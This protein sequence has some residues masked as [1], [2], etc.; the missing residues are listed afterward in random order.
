M[1]YF[2]CYY[3]VEVKKEKSDSHQLCPTFPS[4]GYL[5]DQ[6]SNPGLPHCRQILYHLSHL[7]SP[8][9]CPLI[10]IFFFLAYLSIRIDFFRGFLESAEHVAFLV[11]L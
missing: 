10:L 1:F 11:N 4:S 5:S 2:M 6:G 9:S 7:G 8:Y 3:M